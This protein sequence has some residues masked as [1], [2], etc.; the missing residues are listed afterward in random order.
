MVSELDVEKTDQPSIIYLNRIVPYKNV[1]HLV[2]A[3]N[4]VRKHLPSATLVIAGCRGGAY[5][6]QVRS[7]VSELGL[8][9][10]VQFLGFARGKRKTELLRRAWVH[11]LPS[12]LEGWG[13]SATEA[14]WCGTPT[15]AYD[16]PGLR[17]SVRNGET[18]FLV[19]HGNWTM[20]AQ[21]VTSILADDD[22]RSR[23]SAN[24]SRW[25][26]SLTWERTSSS[27]YMALNA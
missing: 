19:N 22:L 27:A 13:I 23:L 2:K 26:S 6:D 1:H 21:A 10:W 15:V 12:S 3:F 4:L 11:V 16:V 20:L 25:A 24:A 5:E 14:A 8:D 9:E 7:L 18:G 17:D